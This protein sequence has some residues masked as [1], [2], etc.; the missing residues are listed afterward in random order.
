MF[1]STNNLMANLFVIN[2][3]PR[4]IAVIYKDLKFY[5]KITSISRKYW[6]YKESVV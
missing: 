6:I 2:N 5:V 3:L 1:Y 4:R